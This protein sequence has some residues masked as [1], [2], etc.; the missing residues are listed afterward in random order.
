[1]I[2]PDRDMRRVDLIVLNFNGKHLLKACLNAVRAQT[3]RDFSPMLVDNGSSD[4]SVEFVRTEFPEV[5]ILALPENYGFCIANNRGIEA[6]TADYVALLHNDTEVDPRWLESLVTAMDAHPEVGMCASRMVRISDRSTI[7]TAGDL[8]LTFGVA[9][10]RGEGQ[11]MD[12]YATDA[13][14]FGACAGAA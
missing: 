6:T 8:F 12:R 11:P 13:P 5:R 7:D 10:K 4:G 1:M 9:A 2:A 14:V 3:F